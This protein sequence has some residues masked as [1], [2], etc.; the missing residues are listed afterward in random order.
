MSW[1]DHQSIADTA[2]GLDQQ[3]I[4]GIALDL[5]PQPVDLNIDRTFADVFNLRGLAYSRKD[6]FRKAI[7]SEIQRWAKV[8]KDANIKPE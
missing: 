2:D 6:E 4:G 7:G 5:P 1:R 3:G 8:V